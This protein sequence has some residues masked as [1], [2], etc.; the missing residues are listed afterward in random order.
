MKSLVHTLRPRVCLVVQSCPTLWDPIN[1]SPTR[2]LCPWKFSRQEYWS[3]LPCSPP[4]D[5]PD[6]GIKP[7]SL[8]LQADSLPSEPPGEPMNTGVG[9]PSLLQGIFPTQGLNWG[10]LHCRWISLTTALSGKP[11]V[12]LSS[13]HYNVVGV[14]NLTLQRRKLA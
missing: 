11:I 6:P 1:C 14:N 13:Q 9:S 4:G 12:H 5:L 7:T 8:I 2:L 10:L 3:G